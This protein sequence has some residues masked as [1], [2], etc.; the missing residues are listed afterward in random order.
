[1]SLTIREERLSCVLLF[2]PLSPQQ[3]NNPPFRSLLHACLI[4]FPKTGNMMP[5]LLPLFSAG[6]M[7]SDGE[8][9]PVANSIATHVLIYPTTVSDLRYLFMSIFAS[10]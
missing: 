5:P 10:V 9:T 3:T 2:V 1:M 8:W 4:V 6:P 7:E